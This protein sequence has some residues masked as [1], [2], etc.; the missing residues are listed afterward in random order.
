MQANFRHLPGVDKI[1]SDPRLKEA[2]FPHDFLVEAVR[3]ELDSARA[4]IMEGAAPATLDETVGAVLT[5]L[6][7]ESVNALRPVINASGVILHTNLGRSPLSREGIE[8]MAAVSSG[9][10]NLEFDMENG[11]R[12]SRHT[13][14]SRLVCRLTGA[15]AAIVVNNNAS[16]VLLALTALCKRHEVIVSRSQAV[17]IGGGFRVPDVMR[18]SGAKLVEVGTTNCTYPADYEQAVTERTAALLRVHSSNFRV[19]GFT[20]EVSIEEMVQSAATRKLP[21]FDDI[22]SGCLIDT[23]QFGLAPEPLVQKSI[24]AGASLVCFSGDKLMGGPQ[25]GI[26]AGKAEYIKILAKH[27]LVRAMRIDKMRLAALIITVQHYLKGEALQKIPV[28]QMIS[29]PIDIIQGRA[30]TWALAAGVKTSVVSGETMIGGGSLPG[31]SLPTCLLAVPG[32]RKDPAYIQNIAA[33]LR[34]RSVPIVGRI[35]ENVLLLDPRTVPPEQDAIVIKALQDL[36]PV[37]KEAA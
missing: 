25:A 9:Y 32:K 30:N 29:M 14:I 13:Y 15:E 27:P 19:V 26:I 37:F 7:A 22:G 16:A 3:A 2:G 23:T 6:E 1:I 24:A 21:V 28:W 8:A 33:L 5:R 36:V 10:C 31:G 18:Q 4:K 35:N 34:N 12:G 20:N 11:A 17:E